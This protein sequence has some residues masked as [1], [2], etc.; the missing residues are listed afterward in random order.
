MGSFSGAGTPRTEMCQQPRISSPF[1]WK[2]VSL[3]VDCLN[4]SPI[5][6]NCSNVLLLRNRLSLDGHVGNVP[7]HPSRTDSWFRRLRR[8]AESSDLA[9]ELA[10]LPAEAPPRPTGRSWWQAPRAG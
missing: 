9:L 3:L 6:P 5:E 8:G 4:S 7:P 10:S 1:A 2:G